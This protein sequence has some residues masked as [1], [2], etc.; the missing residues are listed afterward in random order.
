M[1]LMYSF[2]RLIFFTN[3]EK[4]GDIGQYN[5]TS[6]MASEF[7]P[8]GQFPQDVSVDG[9]EQ[10]VYWTNFLSENYEVQKT[11]Y[12]QTTVPLKFYPGPISGINLAQGEKYLYVLNPTAAE[13]EVIDKETEEVVSTYNVKAG[14]TA[15]AVAEGK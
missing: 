14:T 9:T 6:A 11:Y 10:V 4:Y 3:T 2:C 5:F 12:N 1:I 8:S 13:L 7:L 15:V